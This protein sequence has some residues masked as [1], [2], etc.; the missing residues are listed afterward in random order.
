MTCT[1]NCCLP[2]TRDGFTITGGALTQTLTPDRVRLRLVQVAA[3]YSLLETVRI[4]L[5]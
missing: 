5:C 2:I 1:E 4:Y 3:W